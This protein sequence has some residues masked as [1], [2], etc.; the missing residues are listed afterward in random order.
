MNEENVCKFLDQNWQKQTGI[1]N[2]LIQKTYK[3]DDY[4]KKSTMTKGLVRCAHVKP[5][6]EQ[7]EKNKEEKM[8]PPH[9]CNASKQ[10]FSSPQV[11][12]VAI[13]EFYFKQE[14]EK[15]E[16]STQDEEEEE[17]E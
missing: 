7:E 17:E 10:Y 3:V 11:A 6:C 1:S 12:R 4:V 13:L 8:L 5:K 15:R 16:A 14:E 2:S 9:G